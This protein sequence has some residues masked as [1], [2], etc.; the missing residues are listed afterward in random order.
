MT[1]YNKNNIVF[2]V[3]LNI[4][5]LIIKINFSLGKIKLSKIN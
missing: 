4:L 5:L 3:L 1:K 2:F